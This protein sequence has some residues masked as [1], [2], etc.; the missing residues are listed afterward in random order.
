M[1]TLAITRGVLAPVV[2]E[3]VSFVNAPQLAQMRGLDLQET[4][5]SSTRDYVNLVS[6]R[7]RVSGRPVHVAGTLTGERGEARIVGID[8]HSIEVPPSSHM[9]VVRNDDRP[10]I[11][12][13]VGTI[14]GGA[15]VNIEDMRVGK[16]P[17]GEAA[18]MAL[19]TSTPV[20][21]EVVDALRAE[22][23]VVDAKA[24]ELD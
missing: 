7:G 2:D 14:L 1:L 21:A 20:P 9:L 15:E 5:T 19:T 6:L 3:P 17:S 8:D 23:G 13:R 11:I 18:L 10:G 22:R 12:G 24:I 4:K 16:S